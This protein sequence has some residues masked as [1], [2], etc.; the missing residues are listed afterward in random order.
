MAPYKPVRPPALR[1]GRYGL[2]DQI[3]APTVEDPHELNGITFED[4]PCGEATCVET[5]CRTSPADVPPTKVFDRDY[6]FPVADPFWVRASD[7]C[8]TGGPG[9][10]DAGPTPEGATPIVTGQDKYLERANDVLSF[11]E[12]RAV[13]NTLW[14]GDCLPAGSDSPFLTDDTVLGVGDVI[15]TGTSVPPA[16]ALSLLED[17]ICQ[18]AIGMGVIHLPLIAANVLYSLDLIREEGGGLFTLAGNRVIVGC[19]YPGTG[20]GGAIPQPNATYVY[21]TGPVLLKRSRPLV[22]PNRFEEA[23]DP[24]TND[25]SYAVERVYLATYSECGLAAIEM[26]LC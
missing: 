10:A 23:I 9:H 7:T 13:E 15:Q 1:P 24:E 12:G 6:D 5:F 18:G 11:T 19:G 16:Y 3:P 26:A 21:A 8:S 17:A 14:T 25:V 2:L 20:P 4:A 22:I